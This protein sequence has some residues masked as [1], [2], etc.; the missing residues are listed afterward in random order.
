MCIVIKACRQNKESVLAKVRAGKL[1]SAA[2]SIS[3]L[4]DE[5]ILSM[6][7]SGILKFL[8]TNIQD[9]RADNTVIPY[10]LV[11]ASAIAAKMKVR[12]SLTDI[13]YAISDHRTLA[14]LGYTLI[15]TEGKLGAGLM[16]EGSL[17][18]LLG[19]YQAE[20]LFN[21]YNSVVQN[22]VLPHLNLAPN[23]HIL[24]CT[25]LEVNFKNKHYEQ[26]GTSVS[27]RTNSPCRG[28][29][30]ATIRGI[31]GDTGII[32]DIR[33]GPINVH[34]MSLS[35]RMIK[36]SPVFRSGDILINDRGFISRPVMNYLKRK[37]NVDTYVPL[38]NNMD[39]YRLA[40][41]C[42]IQNNTWSKHPNPKRSQQRISLVPHVG[43]YWESACPSTDV[44]LN[45]CVVWDME[46]GQ[47]FVFV[48]TDTSKLARDIIKIY[49]LRPEIEED[50]R[51]LK[52][53]WKIE[54]FKSTKI[55]MIAFHIV[56]VLFGYLFFQL[57][58][59]LPDGEKLAGKSL[60]VLLKVYDA[61]PQSFVVLYTDYEFGVITLLDMME[62][63][64][65]CGQVV[66]E[67]IRAVMEKI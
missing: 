20:D 26:S 32:E 57:Y 42:A 39:A 33:F 15:E 3:S 64:S 14:K 44:D 38:R 40:V 30:L 46:N 43:P 45:A 24:D 58:T 23:I 2:L 21:G 60:P 5:I 1:D 52:D 63:Y 4:V 47:Y 55:N 16:R 29:K 11:W 49:E 13:P 12:T 36:H 22:Q 35:E 51:Q 10:D 56:C 41:E 8:S 59:M 54:D 18:A 65:A 9:K 66:R 50:Y 28:Y 7:T 53:F 6:H 34:D 48:T 61:K 25:D 67:K 31:V 62:L 27:K 17:R 37:R 19:K